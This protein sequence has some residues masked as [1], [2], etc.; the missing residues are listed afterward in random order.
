MRA[1]AYEIME[2]QEATYWWYCVRRQIIGDVVS[3]FVRPGGRILDFGCGAGAT[4]AQLIAQGY[5][6]TGTDRSERALRV[7]RSRGVPV[8]SIDYDWA[9]EGGVDCVL[10]CDVLEHVE[11]DHALLLSLGETLRPGG[12]VIVTVPA[13]EFL[14]SGE[15]FVSEHVRRYT[16]R[17]LGAVLDS[18]G[19]E[20]VWRSYFNTLLFPAVVAAILWNRLCRPR[21]MYRSNV[22]ELPEPVNVAFTHVFA[23][24]RRILAL[25][26][27]P[28]GTSVIAVAKRAD[29]AH[30]VSENAYFAVKGRT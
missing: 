11:N 6:A 20:V 21:A 24:E 4:T 18:A 30:S 22:G 1:E 27:L 28:F 9:S 7:S 26:P 3:R 14:W 2:E 19:F 8:V 15:D 16:G 10:L 25:T 13:Y 29:L 5:R 12:I 23:I 17:G